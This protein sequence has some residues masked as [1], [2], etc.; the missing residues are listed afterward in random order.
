MIKNV[1]DSQYQNLFIA[2]ILFAGT[3]ISDHGAPPFNLPRVKF[4]TIQ[5]WTLNKLMAGTH[6]LNLGLRLNPELHLG[7]RLNPEL[8]INLR[9][10]NPET[11]VQLRV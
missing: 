7:L 8:H 4:D 11:T 5:D 9:S 6:E 2:L 3:L 1:L 10:L